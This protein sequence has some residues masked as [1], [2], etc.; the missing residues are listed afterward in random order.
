MRSVPFILPETG[1]LIWKFSYRILDPLIFTLIDPTIQHEPETITIASVEM[2][3]LVYRQ[4]FDQALV[5]H[6]FDDL[7]SLAKFGGQGFIRVAKGTHLKHSLD[8]TLRSRVIAGTL[9]F[10]AITLGKIC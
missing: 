3:I 8:P 6:I 5:Y 10:L 4:P 9:V 7:L 1:G 2:P